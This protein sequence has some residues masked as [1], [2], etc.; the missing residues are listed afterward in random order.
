MSLFPSPGSLRGA[1]RFNSKLQAPPSALA[2]PCDTQLSADRCLHNL[3]DDFY[4]TVRES[5]EIMDKM[6]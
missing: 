3:L 6:G 4:V 1:L 5:F 2:F